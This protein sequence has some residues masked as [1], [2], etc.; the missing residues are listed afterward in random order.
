MWH[1]WRAHKLSNEVAEDD[2][3]R[4][5]DP[6]MMTYLKNLREIV[7][8]EQTRKEAA[9]ALKIQMAW[10]AQ[11]NPFKYHEEVAQWEASFNQANQEKIKGRSKVLCLIGGSD[12][13]KTAKAVSLFHGRV[14]KV[15]C[16]G[17]P[18]GILPNLKGFNREQ[19]KAIV[20]DEICPDQILSNRELFQ[21]NLYKV[22]LGQSACAQHEY[23]VWLWNIGLIICVNALEVDP[24]SSTAESDRAWLDH[25]LVFVKLG[26]KQMW[27]YTDRE[28]ENMPTWSLPR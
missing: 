4:S 16:N 17:L 21:S 28:V 1:Y 11:A 2:I 10:K 3:A 26:D 20:F 18:T 27:Y 6:R 22:K 13:G 8:L 12:S 9:Q 7:E 25:N 5:R 15:S 14:H 19:H 23:A 24:K